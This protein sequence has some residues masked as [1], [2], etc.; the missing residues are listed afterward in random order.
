MS[1]NR[2]EGLPPYAFVPGG[3]FP[4]PTGSPDGHLAGRVACLAEPID[5][6]DWGASSAYLRGFDLF[7][8]GYYWEAHEVWEG[9][10][11]AHGRT[12]AIAELL[13]GLIKIAAAGVKVRQGQPHGIATHARRAADAFR[14]ARAEAGSD[15]LGL[16]LDSLEA[17]VERVAAT[18]PSTAVGANDRVVKVFGFDLRPS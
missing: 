4:H 17:L 6:D 1:E 18:L 5:R 11:H 8:A 3:P 10:W 7:N 16:D 14:R 9:L 15:L 12:G 13:K 2:Q